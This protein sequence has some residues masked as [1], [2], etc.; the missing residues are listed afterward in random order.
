VE[1]KK[2]GARTAFPLAAGAAVCV[3]VTKKKGE[4]VSNY[5][6]I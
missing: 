6:N 3:T 4:K 5:L 1:K 2:N